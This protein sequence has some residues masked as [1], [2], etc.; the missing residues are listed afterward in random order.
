MPKSRSEGGKA[1]ISLP[2]CSTLPVVWISSPAIA[3]KSVVLPQP[4]GPRKQTNSLLKMSR[5]MSLSAT[6]SPNF[7]VRFRILR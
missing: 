5:E 6:K 4:E 2:S 1:E 7:L 3:R